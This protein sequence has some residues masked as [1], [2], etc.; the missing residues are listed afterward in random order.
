[1]EHLTSLVVSLVSSE[2][3][4]RRT[5]I[6]RSAWLYGLAG[7]LFVTG[8]LAIIAIVAVR[9]EG[10]YGLA[11]PLLL[12]AATT[13]VPALV[14]IAAVEVASRRQRQRHQEL[15]AQ[16]F[17]IAKSALALLPSLASPRRLTLIAAIGILTAV[18]AKMDTEAPDKN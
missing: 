7:F 15:Y 16:Y 1:M 12:I 14:L 11:L 10:H 18:F 5:R 13:I 2:I 4:Q 9:I 3:R 17:R 6:Q 8:Y